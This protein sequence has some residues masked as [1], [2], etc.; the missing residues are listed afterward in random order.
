MREAASKRAQKEREKMSKETLTARVNAMLNQT[1]N[2]KVATTANSNAQD[3]Q[4]SKPTLDRNTVTVKASLPEILEPLLPKLKP[5]RNLN[6]ARARLLEGQR[7]IIDLAGQAGRR[8]YEQGMVCSYVKEKI[9]H[10]NFTNWIEENVGYHPRTVRR[11]MKYFE[12]CNLAGK[13]LMY[14]TDRTKT[15]TLSLLPPAES[16]NEETPRPKHQPG[17]SPEWNASNCARELF[18]RFESLTARRTT[19]ERWEVLEGFYDLARDFIN[20]RE[21]DREAIRGE[22]G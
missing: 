13:L 15:D 7:K 18:K 17:D 19:D 22:K 16:D 6:E 12:Q 21:K 14:K 5:P 4:A 10:G 11:Y 1:L 9:G 8:F 2:R 20:S 3:K